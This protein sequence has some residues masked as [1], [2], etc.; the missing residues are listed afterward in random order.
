MNMDGIVKRIEELAI[1]LLA[2]EGIELVDVEFKREGH[3]QV[4]RFLIDREGGVDL[5]ACSRASE[6][7][8]RMLDS[9]DPISSSY[10]LEVCSPGIE[11]PLSRPEDF[12][13]YSGSKAHI[14]T[15]RKILERKHFTGIIAAAT[16]EAV[17][18]EQEGVEVVIPYEE[19][20]RAHLV[21]DLDL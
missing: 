10:D 8:S 4:L 20:S 14:K 11:R 12:I 6:T 3:G 18:I 5:D 17:T 16:E 15:R 21:V 9:E 2:A 7:L 13:R 19:V 1:P